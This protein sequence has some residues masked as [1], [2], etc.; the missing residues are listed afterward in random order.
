MLSMRHRQQITEI[1]WLEASDTLTHNLPH[2]EKSR[3]NNWITDYIFSFAQKLVNAPKATE[4][5]SKILYWPSFL[6]NGIPSVPS[7][8]SCLSSVGRMPVPAFSFSRS[9]FWI[10]FKISIYGINYYSRRALYIPTLTHE[11]TPKSTRFCSAGPF[12][13]PA[14]TDLFVRCWLLLNGFATQHFS[15]P[16]A[17]H[18]AESIKKP[19][20]LNF[21]RRYCVGLSISCSHALRFS[22][23]S[24]ERNRK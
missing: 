7:I 11:R 23:Q 20:N 5:R 16:D 22:F 2:E 12:L 1:V 14:T 17:V 15:L 6:D 8:F 9:R 21:S 3:R 24:F 18:S 10:A 13:C 4:S 19:M